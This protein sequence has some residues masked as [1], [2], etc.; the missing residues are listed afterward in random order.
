MNYQQYT[1]EELLGPL[2]AVEQKYAPV[3]LWTAGNTAFLAE[4]ARVSIVGSRKASHDGLA[5]ALKLAGL[6]CQHDI[7]VIS[8]LAEGIDTAA[9]TATIAKGGRTIAVLGTPLT[10]TYPKQGI[11]LRRDT[12]WYQPLHARA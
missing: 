4:G 9:H 12:L 1:P 7:V 10:Q 3:Q 8:G 11:H 2:N 6:L 5:R